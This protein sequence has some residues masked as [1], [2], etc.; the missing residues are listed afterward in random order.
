M[1]LNQL[2]KQSA[3]DAVDQNAPCN[4]LFGSVIKTNPL[5]VKLN[6][7]IILSDTQLV[8]AYAVSEY[9][10]NVGDKV[11]LIRQQGGQQFIV[12]DKVAV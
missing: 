3:I 6:E 8:L 7:K 9:T 11:I 5:N 2:I 1:R 12:I 4:I 10:L